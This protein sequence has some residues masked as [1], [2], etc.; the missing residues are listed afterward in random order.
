MPRRLRLPKA[1]SLA[2]PDAAA[3]D[4]VVEIE[5]AADDDEPALTFEAE[6]DDMMSDTTPLPKARPLV[7]LFDQVKI[8][9]RS[10]RVKECRR[11]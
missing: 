3:D 5:A 6:A 2:A 10:L 7:S 11:R 1:K 8:R 9:P 4:A